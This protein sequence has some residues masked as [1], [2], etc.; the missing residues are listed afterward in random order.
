MILPHIQG[1]VNIQKDS[2]FFG[3]DSYYF[4]QYGISLINSLKEQAPWANIHSHIFNPT[5]DQLL[6]CTSNKVSCSYEVIESSTRELTTYY[7]C[8]RFIR[9]PEIFDKSTRVI[10]IDCDGIAIRPISQEK[11]LQDTTVS[12]VL[13]REKQ[14]KSLAS[15]VFFGADNFRI[16]Y[17][18]ILKS[19]FEN[20]TYSWYLDQNVMDNMIKNQL[21]ETTTDISWGWY[22]TKSQVLIWT[23][24]GNTKEESSFQHLLKKYKK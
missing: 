18:D 19:Y 8:V 13:W 1:N 9:I 12:K 2:L 16:Q 20:D 24:K 21:V 17:A 5:N 11:F 22:K 23:G 4:N 15:S 10:S 14:Q 3:C 7:A 6:W